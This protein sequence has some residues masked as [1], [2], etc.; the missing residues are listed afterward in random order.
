MLCLSKT[1]VFTWQICLN[2]KY[3]CHF[4]VLQHTVYDLFVNVYSILLLLELIFDIIVL[5]VL[6]KYK[7]LVVSLQCV[8]T[9]CMLH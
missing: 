8:I 1:Y 4:T 2:E 6:H 7:N 5:F 9:L 3:C